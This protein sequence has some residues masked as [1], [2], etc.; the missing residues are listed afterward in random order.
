MSK[1]HKIEI[2]ELEQKKLHDSHVVSQIISTPDERINLLTE[3]MEKLKKKI[4]KK[5]ADIEKLKKN[6]KN[7]FDYQ[8]SWVIILAILALISVISF[9]LFS[10][11]D[12]ICSC[13]IFNSFLN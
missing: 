12:L 2:T 3:N 9:E 5:E 13:I 11:C 8:C 10:E 6:Q 1:K 7:L 4:E